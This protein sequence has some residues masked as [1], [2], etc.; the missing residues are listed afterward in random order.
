MVKHKGLCPSLKKSV[1]FDVNEVIELKTELCSLK[2]K[3]LEADKKRRADV[4]AKTQ[5]IQ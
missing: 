4:Q 3:N 1:E 2:N 5:V